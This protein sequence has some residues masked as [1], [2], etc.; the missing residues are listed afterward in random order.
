V[1]T[2]ADGTFVAFARTLRAAGVPVTP[3]QVHA[4]VDAIDRLDPLD[5][6][7]V[8]W[9]GRVTL[10]SEPDDLPR[11]DAAFAAFFGLEQAYGLVRRPRAQRT[12]RSLAGAEAGPS[13]WAPSNGHDAPP[14]TASAVEV[15]RHRDVARMDAAEREELSRLI[16]LLQPDPAM[17]AGRRPQPAARG[18]V[19]AGWTMRDTLR[20]GGQTVRLLHGRQRPRPRRIVLLIDVS[21]SMEPYADSLLRFAHAAVRRHVGTEVFTLGTR[22]T[23]VTRQLRLRDPDNAMAELSAAV[24]DWSGGTRL[25]EQ[26]QTFLV[27]WGRRGCARGAVVVICSDGWERGDPTLLGEQ[28]AQ[29]SRIAHRLIWVNPHRGLPG[30]EPRA[31]G[32]AAALPHVDTLVAGHSLAAFERLADSLGGH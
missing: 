15:L 26:L 8:F 5:R 32:M 19:H 10:C 4:A 3:Q 11:Y 25:G 14:S 24:P 18:R 17:R 31:A 23:R 13:D 6:E 9:A 20:H 16:A 7:Q 22:L 2:T 28:V 1:S 30:F 27:R 12:V 21:G 29:L